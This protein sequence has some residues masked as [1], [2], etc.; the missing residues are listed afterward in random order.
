MHHSLL[1]SPTLQRQGAKVL[2]RK[3]R[4]AAVSG[5]KWLPHQ[6]CPPFRS[7][8]DDQVPDSDRHWV[9]YLRVPAQADPKLQGLSQLRPLRSE[10]VYHRYIWPTP[11][12][13][14]FGLR[15][16]FVWRFVVADLQV[17]II[18]VDF[19]SF[20]NLLVH[21]RK[22]R[23]LGGTT[24][25]SMPVF[26]V[27]DQVT[28]VK[29]IYVNT[30][31]DEVLQEFP[32]LTSPTG[33]PRY[34]RH[35]TVH[36][37]RRTSGPPVS[38]RPRRLAPDRLKIAKAEF[39]FMLREGTARLSE[40]PWFSALHLDPKKEDS[41]RPYGDCRALNTRT[42]PDRYPVRHIHN[43]PHELSG[44]AVFFKDR[45]GEIIQLDTC[46]PQRLPE[47]RHHDTLRVV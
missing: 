16:D 33:Q 35:S 45:P 40:S 4:T 43:Y 46:P 44:S 6:S 31:M 18:G 23:L 29:T 38:C 42:I 27:S 8:Q 36:Y 11:I 28:S 21:C 22:N 19:L 5:G 9:R 10:R 1:V 24:L 25:L 12:N 39:D 7:R 3:T 14:D 17:P 15:R 41:W 2:N 26:T 47:N 30:P 20:Y 13:V 34:I 37:I 32:N